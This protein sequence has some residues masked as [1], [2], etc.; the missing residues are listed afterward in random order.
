MY[1][2]D[3][4]STEQFHSHFREICSRWLP[5]IAEED[6]AFQSTFCDPATSK[7]TISKR[8]NQ[9]FNVIWI[10]MKLRRD[11]HCVS[12]KIPSFLTKYRQKF[13]CKSWSGTWRKMRKWGISRDTRGGRSGKRKDG[14][15]HKCGKV[16]KSPNKKFAIWWIKH[17][18]FASRYIMRS[19]D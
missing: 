4:E 5:P 6:P 17:A 14:R 11:E 13:R 9:L 10:A 2:P 19:H 1:K 12:E 18:I 7:S 3:N 8:A 15:T 16:G